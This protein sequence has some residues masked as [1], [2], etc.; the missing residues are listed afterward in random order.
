MD[1]RGRTT[2]D[3]LWACGEVA[4][5]GLHGAN[6]LASNSLLEAVVFAAQAANDIKSSPS[7]LSRRPSIGR[8]ATGSAD[9]AGIA[10]PSLRTLL[11]RNLG[12]SRDAEGLLKVIRT[13]GSAAF[14]VHT[15]P[16]ANIELV[17]LMMATGALS[18]CESRGPHYRSD[19]PFADT[20][21]SNEQTLETV[22]ETVLELT[23]GDA[24]ERRVG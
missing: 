7:A 4:S 14:D 11:D 17:A 6:R 15:A 5:T 9:K 16:M 23:S 13:C 22:R 18:R 8:Q 24:A 10:A 1:R 12:A 2:V 20:P 3:G 19:F 21:R